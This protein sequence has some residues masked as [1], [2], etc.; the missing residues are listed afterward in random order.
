MK[1]LSLARFVLLTFCLISSL[2]ILGL[3]GNL[4]SGGGDVFDFE[5]LAL[6]TSLIGLG[7]SLTFLLVGT[8]R[9]GAWVNMIAVEVPILTLLWILSLATAGSTASFFMFFFGTTCDFIGNN[10]EQVCREVLAIE[11][12]SFVTA[13][14]LLG[15]TAFVLTLTIR[16]QSRGNNLWKLSVTEAD[17]WGLS[18]ATADVVLQPQPAIM[19]AVAPTPTPVFSVGQEP[20]SYSPVANNYTT[21]YPGSPQVTGGAQMQPNRPNVPIV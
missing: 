12:L 11:G 14:L 3:S 17:F 8:L 2:I 10:T 20:Y 5:G 1:Y 19:S 21:T 18:P 15:Y 6:A 7:A 9:K 16:A 4:L 13:F